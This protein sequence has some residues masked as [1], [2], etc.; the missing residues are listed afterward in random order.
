MLIGNR[1][2]DGARTGV[3]VTAWRRRSSELAA[4]GKT[5][6]YVAVDGRSRRAGR[7]RRHHPTKAPDRRCA[8]CTMP[9]CRRSCS[10][11]TTAAPPRAV[12][13]SRN[14]HCHRR[15][16][17]EDKAEEV[18]KLQ[19]E[20]K[21]A[22]VGD[23]VNDAPALA[24]ADVGIAIGAGTD[25]AVET[26][27]VVLV[28]NDPADVLGRDL[29]RPAVRGKIKQ[30]LFWAAIYNLIA[31]PIAAGALPG[32]RRA[33][34]PRMGGAGDERLD[35]DGDVNALLLNRVRFGNAVHGSVR[36]SCR[37]IRNLVLLR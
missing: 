11:A 37:T 29:A 21:V 28:S 15:V 9:E 1:Q 17:P 2:T 13:G 8:I 32:A 7:R 14:R 33:A 4:D 23:G 6:M 12:H 27:D 35:R 36:R 10:P 19:A 20:G 3:S 31:I 34:A 26:A 22:M 16:L 18:K 30:N 5:A 24:Q 25:V